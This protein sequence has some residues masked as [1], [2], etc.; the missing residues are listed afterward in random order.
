MAVAYLMREH[1]WRFDS[2]LSLKVPAV[3]KTNHVTMC[4]GTY[5]TSR[6]NSEQLNTI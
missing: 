2:V 1:Q 3:H 6:V 5:I 4:Q